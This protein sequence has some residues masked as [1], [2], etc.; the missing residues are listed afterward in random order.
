M[1]HEAKEIEQGIWECIFD[2]SDHGAKDTYVIHF[3]GKNEEMEF[4][5]ER[6]LLVNRENFA[7]K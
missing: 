2:I 5:T 7:E 6:F 4:I 3:Y 1:W